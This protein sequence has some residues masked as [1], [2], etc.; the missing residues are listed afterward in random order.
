MKN[1]KIFLTIIFSLIFYANAN[2]ASLL[3]KKVTV[4]P[5]D[6]FLKAD[7]SQ[8]RHL[9]GIPK[10][11]I[12]SGDIILWRGKG[13]IWH[14]KTPFS[15]IILIT[16]KGLYQVEG[17]KKITIIKAAQTNQEGV[18]F[19]IMGDVLSGHFAQG[20]KGFKVESLP[21]VQNKWQ[22]RLTPT[23][24]EVK[25]FITDITLE[26]DKQISRVLIQR[27]N[28]DK[29]I[30]MIKNQIVFQKETINQVMTM[31]QQTLFHNESV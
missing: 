25:N 23:L 20:V 5:E 27:P 18:V 16:Q 24:M 12:S 13:L 15:S 28:G 17:N 8:E 9:M 29:D 7:F 19:E 6:G 10:P 1:Y 30:L 22:I 31:Q 14:T 26:G 3:E 4:I 2:A 21:S 11:I